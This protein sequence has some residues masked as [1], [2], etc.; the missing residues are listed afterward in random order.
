MNLIFSDFGVDFRDNDVLIGELKIDI[1]LDNV[2][3]FRSVYILDEYRNKKIFKNSL[4]I[5]INH[6][7]QLN[8]KKV[9]LVSPHE[10]IFKKLG[11]ERNKD[12]FDELII[13]DHNNQ[14]A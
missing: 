1:H 4:P 5:I 10:N 2:A 14:T 11:F 8:I 6:L 9:V 12:G 3:Y 13:S 7:K